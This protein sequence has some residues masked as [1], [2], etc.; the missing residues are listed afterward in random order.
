MARLRL[1]N[2]CF[3]VVKPGIYSVCLGSHSSVVV[4]REFA[5]I[6]QMAYLDDKK[7]VIR[8]MI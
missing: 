8:I 2:P 3:V 4:D 5:I 1:S 6:I 7:Y